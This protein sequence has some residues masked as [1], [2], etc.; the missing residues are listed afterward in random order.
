MSVII[1]K[2]YIYL[3]A[4]LRTKSTGN[5]EELAK[6]LGVRV[7]SLY[8]YKDALESLGAE[9]KFD[10]YANSYYYVI[11]PDAALLNRMNI[12]PED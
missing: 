7:R 10:S 12:E 4:L 5:R 8:N 1:L 11:T 6:K 9:I 3:D 2:R